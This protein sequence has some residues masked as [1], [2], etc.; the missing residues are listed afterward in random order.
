MSNWSEA[1]QIE[2]DMIE[3]LADD[4]YKPCESGIRF[5]R[6]WATLQIDMT[7]MSEDNRRKVYQAEKLLSEVGI[8]FD[9]SSGEGNRDWELDW[10]LTGAFLK[11]RP[12][13]CMEHRS[14]KNL[15]YAY[16]VVYK[17]PRGPV[18]SYA[19]CSPECRQKGIERYTGPKV[20]WEHIYSEETDLS[21]AD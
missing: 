13:Y 10:S 11:V 17:I 21:E 15:D 7:L 5:P 12:I 6:A 2:Q 19:Y 14:P 1:H 20:G 8:T 18:L 3:E 9:T 4:L 16:W